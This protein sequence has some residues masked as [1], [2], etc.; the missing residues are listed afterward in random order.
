MTMGLCHLTPVRTV[1]PK[2]AYFERTLFRAIRASCDHDHGRSITLEETAQRI[3]SFYEIH[4]TAHLVRLANVD[5]KGKPFV[6]HGFVQTLYSHVTTLLSRQRQI[7]TAANEVQ[8]D[9]HYHP[10]VF[11]DHPDFLYVPNSTYVQTLV[12]LRR[13]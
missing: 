5:D 1:V 7:I 8:Y 4:D 13:L 10:D 9:H 2:E 6:Q 12:V 11:K 3:L